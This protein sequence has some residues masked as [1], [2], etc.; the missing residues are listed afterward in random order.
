MKSKFKKGFKNTT[1]LVKKLKITRAAVLHRAKQLGIEVNQNNLNY[2]TESEYKQIYDYKNADK[3]W[4]NF[5]K[6]NYPIQ[7]K[8][9]DVFY[10]VPSKLNTIN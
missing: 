1:Q 5:V 3:K 9:K 10:I 2:F 6:N 7:V 4:R 8:I